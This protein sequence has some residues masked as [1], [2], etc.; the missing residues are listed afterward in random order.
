MVIHDIIITT[1]IFQ[2]VSLMTDTT[3]NILTAETFLLMTEM[4]SIIMIEIVV[5]II[6]LLKEC[7]ST[8][9]IMIA[10]HIRIV[11]MIKV[12]HTTMIE[13]IT[14]DIKVILLI[15]LMVDIIVITIIEMDII[16]IEIIII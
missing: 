13:I 10:D 8:M 1:T 3:S 9:E 11:I 7:H 12:V 16:K 4:D 6:S 2:I 14:M 5:M 15:L